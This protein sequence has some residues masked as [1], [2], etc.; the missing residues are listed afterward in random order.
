MTQP[1]LYGADY[2]VYTRIA[3]LALEEKEVSYH[4]EQID[5]FSD[6]PRVKA[7]YLPVQPF[8]RIPAFIHDGHTI[9]ETQAI[10][11]YVDQVFPGHHLVPDDAVSAGRMNQ[12]MGICDSYAYRTMV[13]DVYVERRKAGEDKPVDENRIS[14]GFSLAKTCLQEIIRIKGDAVWFAGDSISLADLYFAP[15]LA[16]FLQVEDGRNMFEGYPE[17]KAWWK[18]MEARQSMLKTRFPRDL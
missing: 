3:R 8:G 15:I 7:D 11:R 17:M 16:Y 18:N 10:T 12:I 4:F 6:D 9:Y 1:V 2:S 5:I 14:K 13:W